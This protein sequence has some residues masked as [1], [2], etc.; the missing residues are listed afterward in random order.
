MRSRELQALAHA[1]RLI[2]PSDVK[3]HLKR[4]KIDASDA[5]AICEAVTRPS[6]NDHE[7]DVSNAPS[8]VSDRASDT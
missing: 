4:S 2:P 7:C 3:A 6:T 8:R 5:A 1:V